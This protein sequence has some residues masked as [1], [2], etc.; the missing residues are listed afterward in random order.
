MHVKDLARTVG[1][2]GLPAGGWRQ[3]ILERAHAVRAEGIARTI[4]SLGLPAGGLMR[5]QE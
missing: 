5:L 3:L 1:S 4:G 2:L